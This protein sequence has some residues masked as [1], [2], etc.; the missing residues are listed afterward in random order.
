MIG[1]A[2]GTKLSIGLVGIAMLWSLRADRRAVLKLCLGGAI[3]MAGL[4]AV[5]G[6]E[7]LQQARSNSSF[8]S[9]GTPHKVLLSFFTLF[10]PNGLVRTV[11]AIAAWVGLIVVG[12]LLSQVFPKALVPRTHPQDRTPDAIRYTAIYAIAWLV[13]A[14]YSLPWYD[15]IAWVALAAVAASKVDKLM[16]IRTTMLAIAYVPG[17]DPNARQV[18]PFLSDS[19]EWFSM[20]LRDTVCPAIELGVLI[21]LIVWARRGGAQWWPYDWP[22]RKAK[23]A[24]EEAVTR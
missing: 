7:A 14:M 16:V 13:T 12:I 2:G 9:T 24:A 18:A 23:P 22:K 6:L 5:V 8:I 20:R 10:L 19:L 21:G 17:R 4:Y 3:A 11:L 15:V 1:A